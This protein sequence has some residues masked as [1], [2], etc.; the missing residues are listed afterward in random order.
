MPYKSPILRFS[1]VW[2]YAFIMAMLVL[3]VSG[4][5]VLLPGGFAADQF[6]FVRLSVYKRR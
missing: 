6:I 5:T 1:P 4:W 2:Y 3:G